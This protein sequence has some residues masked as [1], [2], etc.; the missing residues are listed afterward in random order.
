MTGA[1]VR[2]TFKPQP[3]YMHQSPGLSDR[4]FSLSRLFRRPPDSETKP[5]GSCPC[6]RPRGSP[7]IQQAIQNRF[8]LSSPGKQPPYRSPNWIFL[9]GV[10]ASWK[11]LCWRCWKVGF[12][13]L[14]G[15][16]AFFCG[17]VGT[18]LCRLLH[19]FQIG[20]DAGSRFRTV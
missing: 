9:T 13:P 16:S 7:A 17:F 15:S 19:L 11:V 5:A 2:L 8:L 10:G 18:P 6:G 14:L 3:S 20:R 12:A 4:G 1:D